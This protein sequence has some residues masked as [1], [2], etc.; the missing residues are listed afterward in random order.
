MIGGVRLIRVR[1]NWKTEPR[2]YN[3]SYSLMYIVFQKRCPFAY[4][5]QDQVTA[6][7]ANGIIKRH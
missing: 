7:I 3:F 2:L 1:K 5:H 4:G 6:L